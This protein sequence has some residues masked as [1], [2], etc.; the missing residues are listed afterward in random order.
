MTE[1]ERG[2]WHMFEEITSAIYG[3]QNYFLQ[4]NGSVYSRESRKEMSVSEA[5]SEFLSWIERGWAEI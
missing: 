1:F 2:E 3:K 5:Y 4:N